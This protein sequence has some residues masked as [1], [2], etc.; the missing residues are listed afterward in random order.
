MFVKRY[1]QVSI[2]KK[3]FD[4]VNHKILLEKLNLCG[5]R[6]IAYTWF[7]SYLLD[8]KQCVKVNSVLFTIGEI[9]SGVPQGSVLGALLFII[10]INDLCGAKLQG[11]LTSFADDTALSIQ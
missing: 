7:K 10:Y 3:A 8:R 9:K 2:I 6:G 4:T 5:I 1:L 11:K